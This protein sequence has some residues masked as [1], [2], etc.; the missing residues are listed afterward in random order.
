MRLLCTSDTQADF[1]NLDLC[2]ISMQ[3]LLAHAH[4]YKPDA[5]IHAG[6]AKDQYK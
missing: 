4:K 1:S 3:E 6:D 2:E 5:I